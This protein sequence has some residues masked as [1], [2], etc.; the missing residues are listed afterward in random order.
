MLAMFEPTTLAI[1][2][3]G[4]PRSDAANV[5]ANSGAEVPKATTVSP[6]TSGVTP[7]ARAKRD[8]WR[9]SSSPPRYRPTK[10]MT[11]RR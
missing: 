1:A 7:S 10:P 6:T 3:S 5:A 11:T 8:A 2:N 9:T 4:T